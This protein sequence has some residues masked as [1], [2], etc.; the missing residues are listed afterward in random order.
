MFYLNFILCNVFDQL[1]LITVTKL[2]MCTGIVISKDIVNKIS[3]KNEK[4]L[5]DKYIVDFFNLTSTNDTSV[6]LS[7]RNELK[8]QTDEL[9]EI[10]TNNDKIKKELNVHLLCVPDD[11]INI[12]HMY[13]KNDPLF[14]P[15]D[16]LK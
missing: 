16:W 4:T 10:S 8:V 12:V 5:I 1:T 13:A 7:L 14:R 2:L 3:R 15:I 9:I 6:S 11:C